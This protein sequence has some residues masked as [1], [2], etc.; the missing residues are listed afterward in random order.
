MFLSY[1]DNEK[2]YK[3]KLSKVN[4]MEL[5]KYLGKIAKVAATGLAGVV[6]SYNI[7]S[8]ENLGYV[9][10][11]KNFRPPIDKIV[12]LEDGSVGYVSLKKN[13]VEAIMYVDEENNGDIER[14]VLGY[15]ND[16]KFISYPEYAQQNFRYGREIEVVLASAKK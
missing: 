16:G 10:F 6:L 12:N 15:V 1:K 4:K 14:K 8:A 5:K 13:S 2:I 3:N 11:N 9:N 7:V